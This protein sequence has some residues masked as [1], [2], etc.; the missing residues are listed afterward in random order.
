MATKIIKLY[1]CS[2][3]DAQSQKWSGRCLACGAWGTL[4]EETLNRQEMSKKSEPVTSAA[5][6][7]RLDQIKNDN[8]E[9]RIKTGISEVDRVFGGGIVPGSLILLSGE[10][11]IGKSTILAQIA[12]AIATN[13]DTGE[14]FYASGEESASQVK[15]R[16]ARLNCDFAKIGFISETNV[17]KI[18]AAAKKHKPKL[19]IIDSIQTMYSAEA[20]SEAGGVNQI[21]VS[22]VKFLE[23]AKVDEISII[24]IG[25]ITKDGQVAGPKSLEHMVDTVIYLESDANKDYRM[26]RSTK[27]RFGSVNE[28]G[29]F[30]MTGAG[31]VEIKNPSAIFMHEGNELISGSAVCCVM[32]GTRP[33]LVEVQALVTKT[34]FGYPQRK[35]SGFDLNRLQVLTAVLTKR[36]GLNLTTQDVILNIVGGMKINDPVLD[37][38]VC[39]A[40][41]SALLNQKIDHKTIFLGEVGLGGEVRNVG[42]LKERLAE[43]AKLG[44]ARAIIPNV[45]LKAGKM[46]LIKVKNLSE[47]VNR[48]MHSA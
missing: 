10:P 9:K 45:D 32:D 13:T 33:F 41:I 15:A 5:E 46:E 23:L 44:Y 3:C 18:I 21:R 36:G 42:K 25:H 37:L 27:N 16:L 30:E 31:F 43:A 35:V 4:G 11:G 1:T 17:E 26:L 38:S 34:L 29:V 47:V 2:K 8:Y 48:I 22:T 20:I 39:A 19:L 6:I 14:V 40:I 7:I 12:N 28:L 24:L